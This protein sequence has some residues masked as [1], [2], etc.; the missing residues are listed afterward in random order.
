MKT[1]KRRKKNMTGNKLYRG[2]FGIHMFYTVAANED[3]AVANI[4]EKNS[5]KHLPVTAVVIDDVDGN[6]IV[7]LQMTAVEFEQTINTLIDAKEQAEKK[8]MEFDQTIKE[9]EQRIQELE[10]KL[11][12]LPHVGKPTEVIEKSLTAETNDK[13]NETVNKPVKAGEKNGARGKSEE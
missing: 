7:P 10:D 11:K 5:M 13:V 12:E 6:T 8:A 9:K 3:E 2:G 4:Q 1:V